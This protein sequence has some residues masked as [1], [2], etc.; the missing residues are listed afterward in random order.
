M[1]LV[2][3]M[4]GSNWTAV[5]PRSRIQIVDTRDRAHLDATAVQGI[6]Y[7]DVPG[8]SQAQLLKI[9]RASVAFIAR[10]NGQPQNQIPQEEKGKGKKKPGRTRGEMLFNTKE[11]AGWMASIAFSWSSV[12]LGSLGSLLAWRISKYLSLWEL[13]GASLNTA[14]AFIQVVDTVRR[15]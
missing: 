8:F 10:R 9:E 12:G 11:M 2:D 5:G 4:S 13:M 15:R 3:K 6:N 14:K 7:T 1:L